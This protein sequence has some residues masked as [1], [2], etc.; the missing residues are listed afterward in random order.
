MTTFHR[1]KLAFTMLELV[2]VIVVLGILAAL[3]LP[4]MDRD[5][6]QE[7]ADNILSAIRYA[8][9]MALIDNKTDPFDSNWQKSFWRFGV[10]TC[11]TAEGDVFYYVGSDA[12]KGGNINNFEAATDPLNGKKM[13]GI[14]GASCAS[15]TNN[16]AS[17]SIFITRKYGIKNTNMFAYCGGGDADAARY[18]GFDH[19]GRPHTGF[20][21]SSNPNYSSI[22]TADCNITFEFQDTNIDDLIITIKKET[23]YAYIDGQPDS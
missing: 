1:K 11:L 15:G 19:L 18:I 5:L 14:A 9:H 7:A 20:S 12:N 22:M 10:R 8:Q 3:A 23:G 17:P 13:L 6:R 4:R 16:D 21:S 2:M